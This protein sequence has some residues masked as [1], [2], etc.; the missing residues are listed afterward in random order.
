MNIAICDDQEIYIEDFIEKCKQILVE[1][2]VFYETFSSGEELLTS[3]LNYDV[4]FL[5]IEMTGM[6]GIQ[7][8]DFLEQQQSRIKI[9]FLT[10]HEER[11]IE[12]FGGN[13]IG[14]LNKPIQQQALE[15]VLKK[16][17]RYLNRQKV[18]WKTDGKQYMFF[19]DMIEYV[20]AKDKYT[21]VMIGTE[22][23]LVR[24]TIKEWEE[25]LSK[26]DF[27]R[28]NRSYLVNLKNYHMFQNEIV[29]KCGKTIRLSRKNKEKIIEQFREYMRKKV[30][31]I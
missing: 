27:C 13:V 16:M 18:E 22:N 12:A 25:I 3:D 20:E 11:M 8:K 4:L 15:A 2:D 1:K 24:R 21:S 30:E 23:F 7:V 17:E 31:E 10:S 28:V 14:F 5:D 9:V 26:T 29:L 19:A 6:D